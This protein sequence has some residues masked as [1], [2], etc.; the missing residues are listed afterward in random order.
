MPTKPQ[1]SA[2]NQCP[3]ISYPLRVEPE[4]GYEGVACVLDANG[5][6]IAA[7]MHPS[8]A[9]EV[10][11]AVNTRI[12]PASAAPGVDGISW[13]ALLAVLERLKS[14]TRNP[15]AEWYHGWNAAIQCLINDINARAAK[16]ASQSTQ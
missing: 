6:L 8:H 3:T 12:A 14:K 4:P 16:L 2:G 13:T 1:S 11:A 5:V 7:M 9:Q 10:T 15:D